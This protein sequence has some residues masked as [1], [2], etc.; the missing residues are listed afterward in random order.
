MVSSSKFPLLSPCRAPPLGGYNTASHARVRGREDETTLH[1]SARA[2]VAD[3]EGVLLV[4]MFE[5]L[6]G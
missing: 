4:W 3:L 1:L 2:E 5:S 6:Y